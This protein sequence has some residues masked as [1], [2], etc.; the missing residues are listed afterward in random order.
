[1]Y[2]PSAPSLRRLTLDSRMRRVRAGGHHARAS[3]RRRTWLFIM[4]PLL[5]R[6]ATPVS[7]KLPRW[8]SACISYVR[9]IVPSCTAGQAQIS[10]RTPR[11]RAVV[12]KIETAELCSN[13]TTVQTPHTADAWSQLQRRIADNT[14]QQAA[15]GGVHQHV[16]LCVHRFLWQP[17]AACQHLLEGC[18]ARIQC[19]H[20]DFQPPQLARTMFTV[21]LM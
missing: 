12:R 19:L 2:I 3:A 16:R 21:T 14:H 1:M 8:V 18:V 17:A 13:K 5:R 7:K 10:P 15:I 6:L 20:E 9:P 4:W 11:H